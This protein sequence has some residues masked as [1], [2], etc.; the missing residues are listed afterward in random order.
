MEG[1]KGRPYLG[2]HLSFILGTMLC[3]SCATTTDKAPNEAPAS[4]VRAVFLPA[5][6]QADKPDEAPGPAAEVK[7]SA[8]GPLQT[9]RELD[10]AAASAFE[11]NHVMEALRHLVGLLAVNLEGAAEIQVD[12]DLER[13]ELARKA[14]AVLTALGGRL[15]LEPTDAWLSGGTQVSGRLR[16]LAKGRGLLPSARLVINYDHGKAVVAD[17]PIRFT[18]VVGAGE[19]TEVVTTDAYGVVSATVRSLASMDQPAVIRAMLVVSN[20]GYSRRIPEVFLDFTYLPPSRTA[21]VL[22]SE[23][24]VSDTEAGPD[25]ASPLVDAVSRG[26]AGT[27]FE[28]LPHL[29]LQSD[30]SYVIHAITEYEDARQAVNRGRAFDIYTVTARTRIRI[31]RSDGSVVVSRPE[32]KSIGRG[33]TVETALAA[34]LAA[35]RAAVEK[36]LR[37]SAARIASALD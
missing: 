5:Q 34:A 25:A 31:L 29:G 16:D 27:G 30:E 6:E 1:M 2:L 12:R 17:A 21:R 20:R 8:P 28:I 36:D 15:T 22:A 19:V 4:P 35:S 23:R 37:E 33:G 26:L 13:S 10:A 32:L 3:V 9:M 11:T 14:D 18:F 7:E 24:S